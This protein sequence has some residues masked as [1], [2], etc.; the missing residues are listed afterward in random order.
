MTSGGRLFPPASKK[1]V[2]GLTVSSTAAILLY[3]GGLE[4]LQRMSIAAALP[5]TLI[6]LFLCRSLHKGL[7][8]EFKYELRGRRKDDE[9]PRQ[10]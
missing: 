1:I 7:A 8:Y 4:A 3:S 2:W 10:S 9:L 5:F 6:M